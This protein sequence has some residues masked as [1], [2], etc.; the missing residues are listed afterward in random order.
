[1]QCIDG[2]LLPE[3][4]YHIHRKYWRQGYGSEA[5]RAV[6]DWAFRN[7]PY[8]ILYSY[9]KYTNLGSQKTALANGMR[10]VKEY[11]DP[12]NTISYA[13]A[14]TRQEWETLQTQHEELPAD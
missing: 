4:G 7:T 5:A 14:I 6:R 8:N 13:F 2:Q 12:K 9:C 1:M 3:I 10:K 11:P